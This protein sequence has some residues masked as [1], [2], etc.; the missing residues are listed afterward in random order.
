M[1]GAR[2]IDHIGIAVRSIANQREFYEQVL[3]ARYDGVEEVPSQ[4]VRVAFFLVGPPG[5]EVR[6]E[7]LEPTSPDSPVAGFLEKRGE[8]IHHLAY[9]VDGI[10]AILKKL[11]DSGLRLIDEQARVGAHH[12]R[13][14]FLHPRASGGVLTEICEPE[15]EAK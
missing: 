11:K 4:K 1:I 13:I 10:D 5:A 8:G 2:A 3:G 14:A 15:G 6:L 12:S 7:L 9:T